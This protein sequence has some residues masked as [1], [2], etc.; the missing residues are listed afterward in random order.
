[1][2]QILVNVI[3]HGLNVA[4]ATDAPRVHHQGFPDQLRIERGISPD[5]IRLLKGMGYD[6]VVGE[7][8]GSTNT[9]ARAPDGMLTGASDPRQRGTLAV[10]Y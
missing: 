1:M 6:V 7:A 8:M 3:D 9:I 2:L 5:T 10:G 4:E